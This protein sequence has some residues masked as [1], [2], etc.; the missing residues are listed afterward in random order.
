M[1]D[2]IVGHDFVKNYLTLAIQEKRLPNTLLFAGPEG[3]GKKT[4]SLE[5]AKYLTASSRVDLTLIQPEGKSGL[6]SIDSVREAIDLS[7]QA[8]FDAPA[9]VFILDAGERMQPA[10]ANALLKT[11][12]EPQPTSYWILITSS[13]RE[14]LPT[15]LS[16]CVKLTFNPLSN[17]EVAQWLAK[18]GIEAEAA[19]F[20]HG[21]IAKALQWSQDSTSKEMVDLWISFLQ[22]KHPYSE[23]L[24]IVSRLEQWVDDE[25]PRI[26][27]KKA[28][29]LFHI[30]ALY[31]R[32]QELRRIDSQSPYLYF[33]N[34]EHGLL[35]PKWEVWLEQA[36]L[37]FERNLK[38]STCVEL[39]SV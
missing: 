10:A 39:L 28:Q 35:F 30:A 17:Q 16:R 7:H 31:F 26:K 5:L 2:D 15:I 8:P 9:K 14:I 36:R 20:S 34:T 1:F 19:G 38:F 3:I 18:Q 23:R 13:M 29:D 11:L 6:H 33:P 4:L 22:R 37:G 32:D 12:E 24:Q 25:D 27:N 21:S